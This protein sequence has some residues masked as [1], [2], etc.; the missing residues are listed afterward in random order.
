MS[1]GCWFKSRST[2]TGY[3]LRTPWRWIR[4]SLMCWSLVWMCHPWVHIQGGGDRVWGGEQTSGEWRKTGWMGRCRIN[5]LWV[6]KRPRTPEECQAVRR[7]EASWLLL[8]ALC[9][10]SGPASTNLYSQRGNCRRGRCWILYINMFIE[11]SCSHPLS[12]VINVNR[13]SECNILNDL[14][15]Q[16]EHELCL[17]Y[18]I[19]KCVSSTKCCL[20]AL[21]DLKHDQV[22]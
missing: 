2:R 15:P 21:I 19:F 18:E 13:Y 20:I 9:V 10:F 1:A 22:Q 17:K 14:Y 11:R 4:V 3:Q 5:T 16:L 12:I 6:L 8:S 7:Q